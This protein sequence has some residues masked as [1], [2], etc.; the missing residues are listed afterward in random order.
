MEQAV[1]GVDRVAQSRPMTECLTHSV[2]RLN[3]QGP[4]TSRP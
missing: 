3:R 2:L 4:Q 1:H